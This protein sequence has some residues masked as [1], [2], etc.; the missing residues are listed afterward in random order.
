M[1]TFG[2]VLGYVGGL[3]KSIHVFLL[4]VT[5]VINYSYVDSKIINTF[6][7]HFLHLNQPTTN[8]ITSNLKHITSFSFQFKLC[9]YRCCNRTL[10]KK[11]TSNHHQFMNSLEFMKQNKTLIENALSLKQ[12]TKSNDILLKKY[13]LEES[14]ELNKK[15]N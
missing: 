12:L 1:Y 7:Q 11:C 8:Q 13:E 15:V 9:I 4:V 2:D 6:Y 5:Y 3:M 14:N 10:F